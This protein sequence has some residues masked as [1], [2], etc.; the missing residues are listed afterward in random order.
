MQTP[1]IRHFHDVAEMSYQTKTGE[2]VTGEMDEFLFYLVPACFIF[3]LS[4]LWR[5][6]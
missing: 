5:Q 2:Q 6:L 3:V 4:Q 1:A